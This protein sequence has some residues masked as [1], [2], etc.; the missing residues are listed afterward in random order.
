MVAYG[1]PN[2]DNISLDTSRVEVLALAPASKASTQGF[3]IQSLTTN[4]VLVMLVKFTDSP[5]ADAFTPAQV[6][7]VMVTDA[8]SVAK[9]YSEVSFGQQALNITVACLT[10][11]AGCTANTYA[12]GWLKGS[13]RHPSWP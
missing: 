2:A 13:I 12:G 3:S 8:G 10:T 1:A 9:Y 6:Y 11:S 5:A 7:Q 4:N